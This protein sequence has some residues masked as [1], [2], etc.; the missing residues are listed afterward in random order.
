MSVWRALTFIDCLL[1]SSALFAEQDG[2]PF[3]DKEACMNGPRAKPGSKFIE[4]R[5]RPIAR[6]SVYNDSLGT[7]EISV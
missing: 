1:V 2:L 6:T 4:S 3:S 5:Q 7:P